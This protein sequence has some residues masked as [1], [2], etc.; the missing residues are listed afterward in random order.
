MED[1]ADY[2]LKVMEVHRNDPHV[3]EEINILND[4]CRSCKDKTNIINI[5]GERTILNR[6]YILMEYCDMGVCF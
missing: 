2:S 6:T 5:I 4:I 1:P 3:N